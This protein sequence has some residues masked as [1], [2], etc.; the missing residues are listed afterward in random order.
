MKVQIA[1]ARLRGDI[2]TRGSSFRRVYLRP[3]T[4]L[5][6][7]ESTT[8]PRASNCSGVL[9]LEFSPESFA[10]LSSRRESCSR[11][12]AGCNNTFVSRCNN[13]S[14]N[15]P[16]PPVKMQSS[17]CSIL[18]LARSSLAVSP[19]TSATCFVKAFFDSRA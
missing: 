12:S 14:P 1:E 3:A 18:K 19:S 16:C 15:A 11:N 9:C 17:Q 13:Y 10:P 4:L 6:P 7:D 8:V 5:I 2:E